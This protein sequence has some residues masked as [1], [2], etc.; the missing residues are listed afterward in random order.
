MERYFLG[1]NTHAGFRGY[2]ENELSNK[3]LVVLL[4]GGPGTGKSTLLKNLASDAKSR[5]YETEL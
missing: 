4:K 3:R 5:G 1:N 2:Y